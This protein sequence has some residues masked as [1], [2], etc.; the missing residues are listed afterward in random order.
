MKKLR[1]IVVALSLVAVTLFAFGTPVQAG[2]SVGNR[3]FRGD[4]KYV[5]SNVSSYG[6]E[7]AGLFDGENTNYDNTFMSVDYQGAEETFKT[8]FRLY[9]PVTFMKS[10]EYLLNV[11]SAIKRLD[12]NMSIH[13]L[14]DQI[15]LQGAREHII[16]PTRYVYG[17]W[18]FGTY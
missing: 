11:G 9:S 15:W 3:S 7:V 10:K 16:N 12:A 2:K 4:V 13:R 1:K 6:V 17:T 5:Y 14:N 18:N 8:W